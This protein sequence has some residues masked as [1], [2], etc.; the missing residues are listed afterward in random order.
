MNREKHRKENNIPLLS[1]EK[2][3]QTLRHS[4]GF[5]IAHLKSPL[6]PVLCKS[7]KS[8]YLSENH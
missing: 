6:G 8:C 5:V 3:R 1:F 4:S 7:V 2:V